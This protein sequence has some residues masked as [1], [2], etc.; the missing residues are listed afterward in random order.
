MYVLNLAIADMIVTMFIDP[1]NVVG[2]TVEGEKNQKK[3]LIF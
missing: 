1:F 3:I 2:E